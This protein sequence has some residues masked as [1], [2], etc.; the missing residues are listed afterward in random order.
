MPCSWVGHFY[1]LTLPLHPG[2][3]MEAKQN[4][5]EGRG[6]GPTTDWDS[7]QGEGVELFLVAS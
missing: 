4:A 7:I 2:T 6:G 5:V 3:V 1:I